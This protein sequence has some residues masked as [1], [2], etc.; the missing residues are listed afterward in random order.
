MNMGSKLNVCVVV[1][2]V[3]CALLPSHIT[4]GVLNNN[5]KGSGALLRYR[6]GVTGYRTRCVPVLR[7]FCRLFT[8]G[9]TKEVFCF[10][11]VVQK[12]TGLDK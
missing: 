8:H 6:R 3:W 12:C 4:C 1:V 11:V 7:K 9:G 5:M 2:L 10:Y